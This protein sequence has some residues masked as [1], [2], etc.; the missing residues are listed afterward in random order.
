MAK[1]QK[2]TGTRTQKEREIDRQIRDAVN[3]L[4]L[5]YRKLVFLIA[6]ERARP[7]C[8]VEALL[9]KTGEGVTR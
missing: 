4:P 8:V 3:A 7:G 6:C 5:V 2:T 9:S 1:A